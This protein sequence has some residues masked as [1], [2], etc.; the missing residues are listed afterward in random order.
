MT[1][2]ENRPSPLQNRV[3]PFGEII[4]VTDR[5]MFMGNRGCIHNEHKQLLR[6]RWATTRWITCLTEFRG[7]KLE[8]M[9]PGRYTQLFFLDE[10]TAFAAGH[11]PCA[12]CRRA[13]FNRF[14]EAW[15]RGNAGS[16]PA[17]KFYVGPMDEQI[18]RERV[19]PDRRKVTF[20]A[21][22]DELPG[23]VFV[24]LEGEPGK[25]WLLWEGRTWRWSPAGYAGS[26]PARRDACVQVL[27]PRS[28]VNAF[29]AG[30]EPV[31]A[32]GR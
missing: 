18:H 32:L 27:T 20:E 30:Y 31:V 2:S 25:S 1:T 13:D 28:I 6:R 4:A 5:G 15:Q 11:R 24:V 22:L 12:E 3:T 29:A 8:V 23:G 19:T 17:G 10:A 16:I 21:C 14:V 26:R 7:R 9:A